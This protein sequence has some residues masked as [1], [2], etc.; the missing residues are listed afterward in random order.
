MLPL[1]P[2]GLPTARAAKTAYAPGAYAIEFFAGVV[3]EGAGLSFARLSG[4]D[5]KE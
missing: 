3:A 2:G 1:P 4:A 5:E